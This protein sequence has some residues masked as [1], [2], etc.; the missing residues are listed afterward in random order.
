IEAQRFHPASAR[1]SVRQGVERGQMECC[2]VASQLDCL[3]VECTRC[4]V[5]RDPGVRIC[6]AYAQWSEDNCRTDE[7]AEAGWN[8]CASIDAEDAGEYR[9]HRLLVSR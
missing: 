8:R 6:M 1:S 5:G 3:V 4:C 2:V 9:R 7:R